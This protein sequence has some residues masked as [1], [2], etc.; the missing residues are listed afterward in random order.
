VTALLAATVAA[1][2]AVQFVP[3][4]FVD[5]ARAA[6]VRVPVAATVALT[7][8]ALLVVDVLGPEG[9]APFIYFGF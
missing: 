6:L 7:A 2:V 8:A 9:V 4:S 1:V 5:D 3:R